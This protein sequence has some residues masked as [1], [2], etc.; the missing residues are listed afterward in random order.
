MITIGETGD[1]RAR[2]WHW[3]K[4]GRLYKRTLCDERRICA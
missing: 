2:T 1:H 3:F 4:H